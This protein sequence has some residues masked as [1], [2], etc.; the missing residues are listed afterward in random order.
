MRVRNYAKHS[1]G[2]HL[3]PTQALGAV[4]STGARLNGHWDFECFQWSERIF[5]TLIFVPRGGFPNFGW[6]F[7]MVC[8]EFDQYPS[9][10]TTFHPF[11]SRD[12][13][14]GNIH[15]LSSNVDFWTLIFDT[16]GGILNLEW[17]FVMVCDDFDQ[18]PS[19][20]AT[21]HPFASRDW[22][23]GNSHFWAPTLISEPS[24]PPENR[25]SEVKTGPKWSQTIATKPSGPLCNPGTEPMVSRTS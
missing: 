3:V 21:C 8:D 20:G 17:S 22:I 5:W 18:Y 7:A 14:F 24:P 9:G 15:F 2:A 10:G 16:R 25:W 19:G 4:G 23:F 12:W 1:C 11:A 6:E 13:I